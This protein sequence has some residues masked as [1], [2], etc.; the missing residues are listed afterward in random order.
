MLLGPDARV[1]PHLAEDAL[2]RIVAEHM[3]GARRNGHTLWTLLT[4]E[5]FLRRE[6][7]GA[8]RRGGALRRGGDPGLQRRGVR[9]RRDRERAR[10]DASGRQVHRRRR[11]LD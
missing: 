6:G 11:R 7:W 2:E 3:S 4:L 5:V 10:S 8:A 1:R 9:R